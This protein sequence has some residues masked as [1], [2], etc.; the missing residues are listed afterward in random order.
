MLIISR[1][2]F[3]SVFL[4]FLSLWVIAQEQDVKKV[5]EE[6]SDVIPQ[7][8]NLFLLARVGRQDNGVQLNAEGL[9]ENFLRG[10]NN[11][12]PQKDSYSKIDVKPI[13]PSVFRNINKIVAGNVEE[14]WRADLPNG[15]S[16]LHA[17][18]ED[19]LY[20]IIRMPKD[21]KLQLEWVDITTVG[22]VEAVKYG[23]GGSKSLSLLSTSPE[24]YSIPW[25]LNSQ[26]KEVN[27]KVL[28]LDGK[29]E[30][31]SLQQK[32]PLGSLNS[33]LYYSI[34]IKDFTGDKKKLFDYVQNPKNYEDVIQIGADLSDYIVQIASMGII[35][36]GE[37]VGIDEN[38]NW[39]P[40]VSQNAKGN[41]A[42]AWVLFPL[43]KQ[44]AEEEIKKFSKIMTPN[45]AY[46]EFAKMPNKVFAPVKKEGAPIGNEKGK[47][48]DFVPGGPAK[49]YE[50]P[51]GNSGHLERSINL[52]DLQDFL[53]KNKEFEMVVIRERNYPNE[54]KN[55]A[56][57]PDESDLVRDENGEFAKISQMTAKMRESAEKRIKSKAVSVSPPPK[58]ETG[59]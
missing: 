43:T 31:K 14:P 37:G 57:N 50:L 4:S 42:R 20:L 34:T 30:V 1:I 47:E 2:L 59:K 12:Q 45:A 53:D 13:S 23:A 9:K 19:T 24:T 44:Q 11:S 46:K 56:I 32:Y 28:E 35:G 17:E 38:N 6:K 25:E 54:K 3:A 5:N 22:S 55:N 33:D 16:M 52:G 21:K 39:T 18:I 40:R 29:S 36:G 8:T 51:K 26:I 49:W 7:K 15:V 27:M 41:V 58:A 10:L 48:N